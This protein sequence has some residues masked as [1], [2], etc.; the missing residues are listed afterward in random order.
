M[1]KEVNINEWNKNWF[2]EM[3]EVIDL[4]RPVQ[5][6][7]N[8]HKKCWS[9]R[10]DGKVLIHTGYV[11]LRN[12]EFKVQPAGRQKVLDEQRKNVHAY[13]KGYLISASESNRIT[14]DVEWTC[15]VVSYNPYKHPYFTCG[16]FEVVRAEIVDMDI[17]AEDMLLAYGM[18]IKAKEL[19]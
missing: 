19:V 5:V 17:D 16:E 8:L 7:R 18:T 13:V 14:K 9:I 11:V 3:A 10:Q 4:E 1:I 6:Y 12:V 15:D 2:A